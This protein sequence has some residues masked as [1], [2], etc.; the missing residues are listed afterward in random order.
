MLSATAEHYLPRHDP[1]FPPQLA[2]LQDPPEGLYLR[3]DPGCLLRPCIAIVGSRRP[4][5]AGRETAEAFARE[6]ARHGLTVVSGLATGID[7]AAHQG[8]LAAGGLT[9]AVCASGLDRTYPPRHAGLAVAISTAGALISEFP[10]GTPPLQ[11]HFPRRNRLISGLALGVVVIEARQRSG[12]L[13]TARL[14]AEQGRE[15]FA[16]PGSIHNPLARGCHRLI[17]DG[18]LLVESAAEVLAGLQPGLFA[19]LP[20]RQT[21]APIAQGISGEPL[22]RQEKILLNACGFEPVDVDVLVRRTGWDV[23]QICSML[24]RLELRGEIESCEG[25]C[26]CR[27]PARPA[28]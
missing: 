23:A 6:F 4:T 13:I 3:G 7:A 14:A 5:A 15:V 20:S 8:T 21:Q 24:V 16:V 28:G 9:I 19:A 11:H 26:Y 27:L 17:R 22:D 25:G 10:P 2:A 12:S 1:T 18:A